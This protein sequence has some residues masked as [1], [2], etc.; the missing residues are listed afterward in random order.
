[1]NNIIKTTVLATALSGA[2]LFNTVSAKNSQ[3]ETNPIEIVQKNNS[4][5]AGDMLMFMTGLGVLGAVSC[6]GK[7]IVDFKNIPY[8]DAHH[9]I[10]DS[11]RLSQK[12]D[13]YFKHEMILILTEKEHQLNQLLQKT[14]IYDQAAAQQ[15]KFNFGAIRHAVENNDVP[16]EDLLVKTQ[17]LFDKA[18]SPKKYFKKIQ[19]QY[20]EENPKVDFDTN[21][22]RINLT[23]MGFFTESKEPLLYEGLN[24]K[25]ALKE[26]EIMENNILNEK[27]GIPFYKHDKYNL[28]KK[29][30]EAKIFIHNKKVSPNGLFTAINEMYRVCYLKKDIII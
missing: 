8:S 24:A 6:I 28:L 25:V 19:K 20:F 14:K 16:E 2:A 27:G 1:M 29:I 23:R 3:K 10:E 22:G 13:K 7:K 5:S 26:L 4:A 15:C 9:I 30:Q 12:R 18:V 17:Y 21:Y 11:V